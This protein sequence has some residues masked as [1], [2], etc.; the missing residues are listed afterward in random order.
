[1][2]SYKELAGNTYGKLTV[3][4]DFMEF[5]SKSGRNFHKCE[6]RCECGKIVTVFAQGLTKGSTTSCG[7][8]TLIKR[9]ANRENKVKLLKGNRY[10][11]LLVLY[12]YRDEK[13]KKGKQHYCH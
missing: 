13:K 11:R 6:C 10:N 5:S 3:M 8:L 7:C 1:M 12:D 9:S 4:R 2:P